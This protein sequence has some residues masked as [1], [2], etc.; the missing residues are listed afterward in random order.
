[1]TDTEQYVTL[2]APGFSLADTLNCGQSFR[3]EEESG[4]YR[5][6]AGRRFLEVQ[7]KGDSL[8]LY[9]ITDEDL[10][11]WR[12]YFDLD[13]P[14][15]ELKQLYQCDPALQCACGFAGGITLLRQDS[16][17]A[18]CSFILSQNNNI[19]RIK[20]IVRR[21]CE[22]FGEPLENGQF[23]FPSPERLAAA[24]LDDLAVLRAGFRAKYIWDAA[25][26]VSAGVINLGQVDALPYAAA[27]ETLMQIHGVGPKVADCAL[28][29]GFHKLEAFPEDVWMKR[30]L[31]S[32]YPQ[33]FPEEFKEHAGVAQQYLFHSIR[34][35]ALELHDKKI[36]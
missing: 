15:T 25:Q 6:V 12:N 20:G 28:L 9:N 7:Q 34:C 23:A 22:A 16:W 14:Y 35:G 31:K 26:K 30:A 19:P 5:G 17:E 32:F 2:H 11:F 29:Y 13:G 4:R 18:L 1:M 24:S 8:L 21:L 33:G 27:K 3:W 36:G 10:P